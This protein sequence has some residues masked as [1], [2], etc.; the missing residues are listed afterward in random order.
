M[1]DLS[2]YRL[3]SVKLR[4]ELSQG[5]ILPLHW[6]EDEENGVITWGCDVDNKSLITTNEDGETI[7][8]TGWQIVGATL[9]VASDEH[10]PYVLVEEGDDVTDI[11]GIIKWDPPL[12]AS[13]GGIAKGNFPGFI[14]KTDEERIQN[15]YKYLKKANWETGNNVLDHRWEVTVKLD[16]SSMTAYYNNGVFGVCSRNLD[17]ME[18]E[19]NSFW[20]T[21][22]KLDLE[23]KLASLGRNIAI[24]GELIGPGIQKN[25]EGLT[26]IDLCVFKIWDIDSQSYLPAHERFLIAAGFGLNHAPVIDAPITSEWTVQDFLNFAEGPSLKADIREGVVFKSLDDPS[27]SFKVISNQWLLGE[28]E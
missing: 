16:G 11:L 22:R 28:K 13:L 1:G 23:S 20:Q 19:G 10:F 6:D 5:L 17:L 15:C 25:L 24:Q 3:R 18:T 21:A 7:S 27:I 14:R 8:V 12:P 9:K 26:E 2:G 4:G